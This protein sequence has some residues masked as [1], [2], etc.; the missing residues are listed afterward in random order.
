MVARG[1]ASAVTRAHVDSALAPF[2]GEQW[3]RPPAYS[4]V[5]RGGVPAYKAARAGTPLHLEPRPVVTYAVD[6]VGFER[7]AGSS[8]L[9]TVE[10]ECGRG[11]YVRTLAHEL[12]Q[13]LGCGAHLR[14]LRR[15]AVGP[16]RAEDAIPLAR[17]EERL[18][19]GDLEPL[20]H[21]PDT[22]LSGWPALLVTA[23]AVSELRLGR[24]L[25]AR[26]RWPHRI[27]PEGRRARCYGPDGR[28]IALLVATAIPDLWH[29]YRVLPHEPAATAGPSE[30][31][32]APDER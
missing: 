2:R 4:A 14:E 11:Y 20:V 18:A 17:A 22:V 1:D 3:Q 30:A 9:A 21:A 7:A 5:K 12:G 28:L 13:A 10:V 6:L 23:G 27:A 24:D 25:P 16:F 15:T 29:P 19:A 8:P 31:G 32:E 26:R